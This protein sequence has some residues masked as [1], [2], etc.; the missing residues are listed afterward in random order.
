MAST[1][2]LVTVRF[3]DGAETTISP[4]AMILIETGS[5]ATEVDTGDGQPI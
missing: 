3:E 1:I 5:P 4:P 2:R